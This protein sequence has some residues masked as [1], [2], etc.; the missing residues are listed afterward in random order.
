MSTDAGGMGFVPGSRPGVC[1]CSFDSPI[2]IIGP[3]RGA[4]AAEEE[5]DD[6]WLAIFTHW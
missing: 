1:R 5:D 3:L 6:A 4:E 2:G